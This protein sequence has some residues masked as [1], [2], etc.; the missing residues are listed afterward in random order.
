M[1]KKQASDMVERLTEEAT[2]Y[3]DLVEAGLIEYVNNVSFHTVFLKADL[4][5]VEVRRAFRDFFKVNEKLLTYYIGA[6]G[7]LAVKYKYGEWEVI[8]YFSDVEGVLE[9]VSGGRCEVVAQ[10]VVRVEKTIAC[11]V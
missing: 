6:D 9:E 10:E 4:N 8:F 2:M 7:N 11:E 5:G 1:T 3:A